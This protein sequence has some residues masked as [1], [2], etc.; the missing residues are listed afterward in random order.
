MTYKNDMTMM[1]ATHDAL[2]R[3]LD[4]IARITSRGQDDPK[5][6]L[7]GAVG[8][9]LFKTF[10]QVH[11]SAE[12]DLLWPAMRRALAGDSS[13]QALLDAMEAEH[14]AIDPLLLAID[15]A[16]ADRDCG[17]A[18]LGELTDSLASGLRAH[19]RHEEVDV[20]PLIDAAVSE[21]EWRSFGAETG[22]RVGAD[23]QRFFPWALEEAK[24]EIR[25]AVLGVL[26]PP[27]VQ[28]YRDVWQ[29]SYADLSLWT[30]AA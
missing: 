27:M 30:P 22:A 24:P 15:A 10:L 4:D 26:P 18:R 11:H 5:S 23:L 20:L 7:R 25:S 16:S 3:D 9:Q 1:Y 29:P 2:R 6:I 8:W 12:D 14:G 19:L 28:A 13:A 17:P 21:E